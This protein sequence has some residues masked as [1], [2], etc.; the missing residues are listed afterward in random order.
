MEA[1]SKEWHKFRHG[2]FTASECHKLMGE[3]G[4]VKTATAHTYIHEKVAETL[5]DGWHDE[6][7]TVA[8]RWGNEYEPIAVMYYEAAFKCNVIKPDPQYPEW[9]DE[10]SSSPDGIT[11]LN[12]S[13]REIGQEYKCPYNP[14]NHVKYMMMRSESDLKLTYKESYWQILMNMLIWELDWE[15]ISF[16]PRFT[17]DERMFVL[18]ISRYKVKYDIDEL[19]K[20]LL[21]AVEEKKRILS[22]IKNFNVS[23]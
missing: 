15:F 16:D 14:A 1:G 20:N 4:G 6:M 11:I 17:G 7:S 23:L 22:I 13:I 8:T 18:P 9:C 12:D 3:K 2:R 10:I 19:K 21:L 5:T